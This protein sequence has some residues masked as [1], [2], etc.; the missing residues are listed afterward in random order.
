M[1]QPEWRRIAGIHVQSD[2]DI[3]VVWMAHD[4]QSDVI[5]LYDCCLFRREVFAVIAEGINCRGKWVPIAWESGSKEVAN[6]LLER[7][8]NMLPEP[9][10]DDQ[11]L[12]EV[13][14]RD[15]L[16]RMKTHRIKVD[17]RLSEWLDEYRI[18]Y[19][20]DSQVPLTS[21]P[22]MSATRHAVSQLSWARRQSSRIRN[23]RYLKVAMI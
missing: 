15:I 17:K 4:K 22:L 1:I 11:A 5:H 8:C 9:I 2:A 16:E 10:K 6:K 3:G 19:R 13:N 18:F 21:S 12:A 20:Q 23:N 14:S 7:G